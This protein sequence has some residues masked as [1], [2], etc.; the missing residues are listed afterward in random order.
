MPEIEFV[1]DGGSSDA[2]VPLRRRPRGWALATAVALAGTALLVVGSRPDESYPTATARVDAY[3][4]FGLRHVLRGPD[5]N[6]PAL[7]VAITGA[8]TW[9]LQHD[10][11]HIVDAAG[12]GV[13]RD[14]R[15]IS[16]QGR[17]VADPDGRRVWLVGNGSAVA[18]STR[19]RRAVGTVAAPPATSVAAMDGRLFATT[20][21]DLVE[22]A[23]RGTPPRRVLTGPAELLSVAADPVRA[24][25]LV[26]DTRSPAHVW[27][28]VPRRAG[29]GRIEQETTIRSVRPTLGV[30][31]GRIWL[32]GVDTGDGVLMRL[33]PTTLHP[34]TPDRVGAALEPGAVVAAGGESTVW[35]RAARPDG[36]LHCDDAVTGRPLQSWLL[37]GPVASTAGRAVIGTANGALELGLH[38]CGG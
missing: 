9:V 33:D 18:Y 15:A 38:L 14:G 3:S 8:T 1:P 29:P 23:P 13:R 32:A 34:I 17:L 37:R 5:G 30:A 25:L 27:A 36:V 26:T 24:R 28:V 6:Q 12:R 11:L 22:L 35:V 19:T 21:R 7:A 10:G 16:T 31:G 20:G 2:G 4:G